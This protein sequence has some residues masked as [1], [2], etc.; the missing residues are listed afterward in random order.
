MC[1]ASLAV[2]PMA[3]GTVNFL[4][5]LLSSIA[6][7]GIP[8]KCTLTRACLELLLKVSSVILDRGLTHDFKQI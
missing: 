7:H 8:E 3:I 1:V 4:L 2:S 5:L 6:A